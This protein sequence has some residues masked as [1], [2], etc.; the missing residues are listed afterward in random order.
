M[1]GTMPATL[2]LTIPD[3]CAENIQIIHGLALALALGI[4]AVTGT[5]SSAIS[6]RSSH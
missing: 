2:S 1:P 5:E 6:I 4:S 3:H